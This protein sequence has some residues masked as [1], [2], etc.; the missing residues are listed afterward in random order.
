MADRPIETEVR[1][2]GEV[3]SGVACDAFRDEHRIRGDHATDVDVACGGDMLPRGSDAGIAFERDS[4]RG[5]R[6]TSNVRRSRR[7]VDT[8]LRRTDEPRFV[9][10]EGSA[11]RIDERDVEVVDRQRSGEAYRGPISLRHPARPEFASR[12][13]TP[14][15]EQGPEIGDE[16]T[17]I[18]FRVDHEVGGSLGGGLQ[19]ADRGHRRAR[20]LET[21]ALE[22]ESFT[23][24]DGFPNGVDIE[25]N[26]RIA[27]RPVS[28]DAPERV[29]ERDR[30]DAAFRTE[31]GRIRLPRH[32][33][34]DGGSRTTEREHRDVDFRRFTESQG[35]GRSDIEIDRTDGV[36]VPTEPE[37]FRGDRRLER[38]AVDERRIDLEGP[39]ER[40]RNLRHLT[41]L[42]HHHVEITRRDDACF[43]DHP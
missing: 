33:P 19:R 27:H 40:P 36:A 13:R 30:P 3:E 43:R 26:R 21:T 23:S 25:T 37:A 15:R 22:D 6:P 4:R 11:R 16:S 2:R 14:G 35:P 8:G 28:R 39:R 7:Q 38:L 10:A 41:N 20:R 32:R 17:D 5:E 1:L 31:R 18:G 12:F 24:R 42:A 29:H 34:F 9:E